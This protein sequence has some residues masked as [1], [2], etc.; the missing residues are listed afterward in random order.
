MK[1]QGQF[2]KLFR[3]IKLDARIPIGLNPHLC[4]YTFEF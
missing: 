1:T 3:K 2:I 4:L